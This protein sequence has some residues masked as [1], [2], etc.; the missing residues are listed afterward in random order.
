M[1]QHRPIYVSIELEQTNLLVGKLF[2]HSNKR[3]VT[4][5]F[6]YDPSWLN[7]P[8]RFA[9]DPALLM[10]GGTFHTNEDQ[11]LFGAIGD[12]APDCWGRILM[13]RAE[14]SRS[15]KMNVTPRTLTEIDYLLG[16]N[17]EV[18]QG[19]LRFSYEK[20]GPYQ[21]PKGQHSIPPLMSL[22]KLLSATDRYLED[23]ETDQDLKMLLAPGSSLGGARPKASVKDQNGQLCIAKL[24]KNSDTHD[25]VLWE[26]V[27][28]T[29]A[30]DAG[31]RVCDFFLHTVND[32]PVLII[33]RFDRVENKRLPFLSAMSLLGAKDNEPHSYLDIASAITQYGASP[34]E[35]MEELWKRSVFDMMISNVDNHLR[36]HG[37]LYARFKGWRLSPAYDLNPTPIEKR[38]RHFATSIDTNHGLPSV[39]L[40]LDIAPL[41]RVEPNQARRLIEEI[42]NA[43]KGWKKVAK[44]VGLNQKSIKK[45]GTAF[46]QHDVRAC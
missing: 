33:K 28:L 21:T 37:F 29:L 35:D 31:I 10:T 26:A 39:K 24:P 11:K 1:A 12:S 17:D 15:S 30:K 36:N 8:E 5:S 27:A 45:M 18:R 43:V 46:A 6:Q 7:H 41:F 3:K 32:R 19:A 9:I 22:P 25:V 4:T 20:G 16:V 42:I 38:A 44:G 23:Q 14:S 34:N 40:A 2:H 13:M